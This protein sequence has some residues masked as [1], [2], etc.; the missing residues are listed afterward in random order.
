[1]KSA[2]VSVVPL[3]T[4]DAT[5]LEPIMASLTGRYP[6]T[7][8]CDSS[9]V[10]GSIEVAADPVAARP[11]TDQLAA[12]CSQEPLIGVTDCSV[13]IDDAVERP[14]LWGYLDWTAGVS[15]ISRRDLTAPTTDGGDPPDESSI[16]ARLHERLAHHAGHLYGLEHCSDRRCIMGAA[17][18]LDDID[19]KSTRLCG[20]C[21]RQ[22]SGEAVN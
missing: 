15:V 12:E 13:Y 21:Q 2:P 8:R 1:M 3:G 19:M 7:F 4:V 6:L 20:S 14:Q 11:I 9:D 22:L 10:A 17:R 18:T 16:T 5:S